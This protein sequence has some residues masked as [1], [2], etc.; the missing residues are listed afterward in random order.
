[1]GFSDSLFGKA[2]RKFIKRKD[3]DA[4]EAGFTQ[5]SSWAALYIILSEFHFLDIR[6]VIC[7]IFYLVSKSL[8]P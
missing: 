7:I 2:A 3:S 5:S 4:G 8:Y 6:C 1:M